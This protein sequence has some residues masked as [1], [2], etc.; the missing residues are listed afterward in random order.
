MPIIFQSRLPP[1]TLL[2]QRGDESGLR[3]R[4]RILR[5]NADIGG[6]GKAYALASRFSTDGMTAAPAATPTMSAICWR[7]GGA[8][9]LA[10]LQILQVVIRDGGAGKHDR[11]DKQ[12]EGDQQRARFRRGRDRKRDESRTSLWRECRY[13]KSGCSM[14]R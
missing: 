6:A 7:I 3:R 8:H 13:R 12:G 10:G 5:D 1:I 2:C 11:R 9:E 14:R 4:Q